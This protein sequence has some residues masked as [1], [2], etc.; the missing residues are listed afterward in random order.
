MIVTHIRTTQLKL[1]RAAMISPEQEEVNMVLDR[2]VRQNI[3]DMM[4]EAHVQAS[5][6]ESEAAGRDCFHSDSSLDQ[7][8]LQADDSMAVIDSL[9]TDGIVE[10]DLTPEQ[11][12]NQVQNYH[13]M[14]V[15]TD[16]HI[17]INGSL[18][19]R[20]GNLPKHSVKILKRWLYEHRY[21][22]YPSDAEK[23]TL[24]QEANLTVLQVCNWF[25]NAR[26]RIL[27]EMIRREGNDPLHFTISRR[28]KKVTPNCSGASANMTG[29]NPAH[30]SPASEVVVG[31]TEE[32]DGAGEIHEGIANVLTN[33]EQ[34][35]RGPN[36]QMVKM[37]PEYEDS[38][39]YR[40]EGEESGQGYESCEQNSEEEVRFETSDDWQSVMKTV[41]GT[42]EVNTSAGNNPSTSASKG[43]AQNTAFWNSNQQ[44]AK[45]D[46]NQELT[47]YDNELIQASELLTINP[48]SSNQ[49]DIGDNLQADEVFSSAEAE[50]GQNQ[51][52]T[53][54][55][56]TNPNERD[57]YKCL[58]YLVETAM[59]VRQNDDAQDDDFV[60]MGD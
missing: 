15:E 32:V 56:G 12:T 45:R 58:Y 27:P 48:T 10:E 13:D 43:S 24:S 14:M 50:I 29:P 52:S 21:N 30:G 54:S 41:F 55:K 3:Q 40:S 36:G 31:A 59:A 49:Q 51:L 35:V 8:S 47:D 19:K 20:R 7:D 57:K 60:Y 9:S 33:F 2:H 26:R 25:I 18:R 28:G 6:L 11:T 23:Y 4:H 44:I 46:V 22:A 53:L 34:Y 38:V 1:F 16:H 39:I 5:L 42:E 37:E 17:D